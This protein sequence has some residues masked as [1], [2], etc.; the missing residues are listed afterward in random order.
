MESLLA[1]RFREKVSK[2]KDYRM[3][4]EMET[5]VGYPSGFLSFDFL[6][7]CVVHVKSEDKDFKYYSLGVTDGSMVTVIGRSGAGKT[8]WVIQAAAN[9][10]R[11]FKT[12]TIFFDEI[13]GGAIDARMQMLSKFGK[14]LRD[15]CII[16]NTGITAE[17]FYERIRMIYDIKTSDRPSF[18]YDTGLLDS[19]GN[20]I[21]KLEPTVVILDSL[22]LLMPEKYVDEEEL[23]GQMSATA[24][25]R[26]NASI[27]RRIVPMLKSANII[28]FVIN[29]INQKVDVSQFQRTKASVSYLKQG[30]TLPGGNAP[31]YLCNT[32][33]RFDD[34]N[35]LEES[36]GFGIDGTLVDLTLVKSRSAK[37]GK[38]V[39]L[40][41]DQ[42]NG[43]DEELSLFLLLKENGRVGGAGRSFHIGDNDNIKFS[44]KTFKEKLHE[45]LE[46]QELFMSEVI[47]ILQ[48]Q[49]ERPEKEEIEE[50]SWDASMS[51]L[52]RLAEV[53]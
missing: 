35:K 18:E 1:S 34:H 43:F 50:E 14:N 12:S 13:E 48:A 32:M 21:F 41:F 49:L 29:H 36:E 30:E 27:F 52:N 16:R 26:A 2:L 11:K 38:S 40:V 25:A 23:S 51:I 5:D 22:S 44:Q 33:I 46:L 6:N 8:T 19:Y 24:T 4:V 9:I 3:K 42:E 31:I 28:L 45:S 20:R 15:R 47:A 10:I 7:G 53:A 39:T 37:A 17:N